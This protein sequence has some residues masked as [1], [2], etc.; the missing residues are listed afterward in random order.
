MK[1]AKLRLVL[2]TRFLRLILIS[3][4]DKLF[5]EMAELFPNFT[6]TMLIDALL[7]F[8]LPTSGLV[9]SS[10]PMRQKS[11]GRLVFLEKLR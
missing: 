3:E 11:S 4:S 1:M 9:R 5:S 10:V 6:N 2:P 7:L 8:S